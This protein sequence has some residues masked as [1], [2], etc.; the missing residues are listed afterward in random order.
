[1]AI[2][3]SRTTSLHRDQQTKL[4][5]SAVAVLRPDAAAHRRE[6]AP[7]DGQAHTR[8]RRMAMPF[9][10]AVKPIENLWQILSRDAWA[11]IPDGKRQTVR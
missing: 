3:S 2:S 1:L 5:A 11:F 4:G 9:A 7:G 6:Q 8:S 10:S